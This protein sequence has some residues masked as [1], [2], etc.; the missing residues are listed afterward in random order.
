[1]NTTLAIL[2]LV[3]GFF[4]SGQPNIS[5]QHLTI[6]SFAV[7]S[8]RVVLCPKS[9]RPGGSSGCLSSKKLRLDLRLEVAGGDEGNL[10]YRYSVTG[11]RIIGKGPNVVWEFHN[12]RPGD[13]LADVRVKNRRGDSASSSTRAEFRWCGTCEWCG[14]CD[15]EFGPF[16]QIQPSCPATVIE[17]KPALIS[18]LLTPGSYKRF[19]KLKYNWS[20]TGVG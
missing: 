12:P 8:P 9:F 10:E 14:N 11:G 2:N 4:P 5:P 20:V 13:Y 6:R 1:M 15:P 16:P 7:T 19:G 18:I 3:L 17:G